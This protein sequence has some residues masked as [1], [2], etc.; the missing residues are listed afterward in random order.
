MDNWEKA[1]DEGNTEDLQADSWEDDPET[2]PSRNVLVC[3]GAKLA[4]KSKT[5]K[6]LDASPTSFSSP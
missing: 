3:T 5:H 4:L 2:T 6:L 1:E